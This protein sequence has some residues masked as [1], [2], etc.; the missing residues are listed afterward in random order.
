MSDGVNL[1]SMTDVIP[2]VQALY[3]E[4]IAKSKQFEV[5]LIQL[6][7]NYDRN[8]D[9]VVAKMMNQ[10]PTTPV[11]VLPVSYS[12]VQE[13]NGELMIF[14]KCTFI[15]SQALEHHKKE[16]ATFA[17]KWFELAVKE[18]DNE[19]VKHP[20]VLMRLSDAVVLYSVLDFLPE[21][22]ALY[23]VFE[24]KTKHIEEESVRLKSEYDEKIKSIVD[25]L[26]WGCDARP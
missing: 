11:P 15:C 2:I 9:N 26:I 14:G 6:K 18:F 19:L 1:C 8:I 3:N 21:V 24:T 5:E 25:A 7:A 13:V 10:I 4:S 22:K 16:Y 12:I 20:P 17:L 23:A